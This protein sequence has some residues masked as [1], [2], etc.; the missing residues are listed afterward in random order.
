MW[1]VVP[2]EAVPGGPK[3]SAEGDDGGSQ[4]EV[5]LDAA[6]SSFGAAAQSAVV[7]EPGVGA[8]DD[9]ALADLDR[10]RLAAVGDH[11]VQASVGQFGPAGPVVIARVQVHG[12]LAGLGADLLE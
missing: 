3:E 9:P 12:R 2:A 1:P 6:T 8:L 11:R 10:C 4:G 5:G 7:V